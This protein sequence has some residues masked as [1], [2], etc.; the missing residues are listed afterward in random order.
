MQL[1][2]TYM[3]FNGE[4]FGGTFDFAESG[5]TALLSGVRVQLFTRVLHLNV[6]YSRTY[7]VVRT[8]GSEYHLGNALVVDRAGIPTSFAQD[9]LFDTRDALF[10]QLEI[11]YEL[12]N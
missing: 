3:R 11:G 7:Q 4:S 6:H 5:D 2:A 12:P 8:A 1:F 10:V 9:R